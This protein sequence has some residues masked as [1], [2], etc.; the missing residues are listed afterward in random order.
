MADRNKNRKPTHEQL[1]I[2]I[3]CGFLGILMA[4]ST[5][6]YVFST[7]ELRAANESV[8]S[9]QEIAVGIAYGNDLLPTYTV[10]CKDGFAVSVASGKNKTKAIDINS[11]NVSI[12]S[13]NNL[14]KTS[15]GYEFDTERVTVIGG[16]HV[17]IS[18]YSFRIGA[19]GSGDNPV[20]IFP[21]GS[22]G[23]SLD[24]LGY[25]FDEV[26][27]KIKDLNESGILE[28]WNCYSYPVYNNGK[29]SIPAPSQRCQNFPHE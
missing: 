16:Y 29:Y 9:E 26:S 2:R 22:S 20:S 24:D 27:A 8:G 28:P 14:Y 3:L 7:F 10:E 21:G 15:A 4:L 1:W 17:Q 13:N 5:L 6:F 19:D 25:T 23:G 12:A 11:Q 18:S